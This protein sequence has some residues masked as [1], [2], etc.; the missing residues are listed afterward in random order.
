MFKY[1]GSRLSSIPTAKCCSQTRLADRSC[2]LTL[3]IDSVRPICGM[4]I[5]GV[6]GSVQKLWTWC[7]LWLWLSCYCLSL[8]DQAGI[9]S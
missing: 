6:T 4:A 5:V 1:V 7:L 8:I 9:E 3:K 2:W